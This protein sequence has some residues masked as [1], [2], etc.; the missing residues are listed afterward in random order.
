MEGGGEIL[1]FGIHQSDRTNQVHGKILGDNLQTFITPL[2][3]GTGNTVI[4]QYANNQISSNQLRNHI[5]E[6]FIPLGKLHKAGFAHH[7]LKPDNLL[8]NKGRLDLGDFGLVGDYNERVNRGTARFLPV[9]IVRKQHLDGR[10]K[11]FYAMALT[12]YS[13]RSKKKDVLQEKIQ[14]VETNYGANIR[15]LAQVYEIFKNL[16]ISDMKA[17]LK[18]DQDPDDKAIVSV[19]LF[20]LE[21]Y[22]KKP[23][24]EL[25]EEIQ[26]YFNYRE[27]E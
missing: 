16:I 23:Y 2:A 14:E 9:E 19:I 18:D 11:D 13:L 26:N 21:N 1:S 5:N 20:I 12:M 25:K 15:D 3:E 10:V 27:G 17:S 7:D 4:D 8:L 22:N 24:D 6:V